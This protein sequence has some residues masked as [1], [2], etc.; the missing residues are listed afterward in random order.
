MI[1]LVLVDAIV[2]HG[3]LREADEWVPRLKSRL[4]GFL[5]DFEKRD[6]LRTSAFVCGSVLAR[7]PD[8]H[9]EARIVEELDRFCT[10]GKPDVFTDALFEIT[11]H[12]AHILRLGRL[13]Y[14]NLNLLARLHGTLKVCLFLTSC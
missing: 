4:V 3:F 6:V 5:S 2:S 11:R 10:K 8:E 7:R 12:H 13:P 1:A 9:F 14:L